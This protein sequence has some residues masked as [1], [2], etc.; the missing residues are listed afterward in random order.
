MDPLSLYELRR[1]GL[2]IDANKKQSW[3]SIH[4]LQMP[5]AVEKQLAPYRQRIEEPFAR[6]PIMI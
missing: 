2:R 5:F 4:S 1:D 3:V 6:H